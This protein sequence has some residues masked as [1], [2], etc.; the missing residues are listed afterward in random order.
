MF[1]CKSATV[2]FEERTFIN[3]SISPQNQER[4]YLANRNVI[5]EL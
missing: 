1:K 2:V 5:A 3:T 4:F